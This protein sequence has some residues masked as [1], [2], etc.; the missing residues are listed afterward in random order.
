MKTW[1][2]ISGVASTLFVA[3]ILTF[4]LS[5]EIASAHGNHNEECTGP[6]KNDS[7]CDGGGGDT[8][9]G[10]K[11]FLFETDDVY[12]PETEFDICGGA[13]KTTGDSHGQFTTSGNVLWGPNKIHVH[14]KLQLK[15]V[16]PGT[17][18]IF[19]NN[20]IECTVGQVTNPLAFPACEDGVCDLTITVKQNR[21]GRT[22]GELQLP[23]QN[24]G[25]TTTVW[26]TV[27]INFPKI[28]RSTPV[29]IV[30]PPNAVGDES[31]NP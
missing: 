13:T 29:T 18:P 25:E 6:H 31:C 15:D 16:D 17:Y 27:P 2:V 10:G 28:L 12:I 30:L 5:T 3:S 11:A 7:G 19:G 21:Q 9:E 14:F 26:V 4:G 20:G 1:N 24:C 8:S 23:G 22:S